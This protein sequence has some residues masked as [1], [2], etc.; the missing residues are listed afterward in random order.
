VLLRLSVRDGRGSD[1]AKAPPLPA[2]LRVSGPEPVLPA[3]D[4]VLP[5]AVRVREDEDVGAGWDDFGALTTELGWRRS[6]DV[7]DAAQIVTSNA[8][9]ANLTYRRLIDRL[10][11]T[12]KGAAEVRRWDLGPTSE[13]GLLHLYFMHPEAR[14][15]R[16]F[17]G[18]QA[19]TQPQPSGRAESVNGFLMFEPIATL[20][21]GLHFVSKLGLTVTRQSLRSLPRSMLGLVDPDVF[22]D[23][24]H[25]H[26][27]ALFL[28]EGFEI[29]P[30]ADLLMYFG[31]RAT[32]GPDFSPRHLDRVAPTMALRKVVGRLVIDGGFRWSDFLPG[33]LRKDSY[34]SRT[35]ALTLT[36]TFWLRR[37][38]ALVL[39]VAGQYF[40]DVHSPEIAISLGWE[41]SNGRR[42]RDHTAVEGENYFYPQRGPGRESGRLLFGGEAR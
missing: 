24:T 32:S 13:A 12:I 9:Y 3:P 15:A 31:A 34:Q 28:E 8:A 19:A 2:T 20:R 14:W 29:A 39:T 23:Y 42:L 11:L 7:A 30:L 22:N 41:I 40:F 33:P 25:D 16:V 21:S 36:Q 18:L 38:H 37:T 1:V 5:L 27:R 10:H 6:F 35:A 17:G 26:P 4:L